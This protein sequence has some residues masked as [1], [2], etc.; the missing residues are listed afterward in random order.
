MS[1]T[2]AQATITYLANELR[3][4]VDTAVQQHNV[5]VHQRDQLKKADAEIQDLKK[6]LAA[7]A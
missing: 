5:L 1:L 2:E 6:Q 7:K 4:A 3:K